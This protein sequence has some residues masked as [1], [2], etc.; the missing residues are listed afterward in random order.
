MSETQNRGVA[1]R[2]TGPLRVWWRLTTHGAAISLADQCVVSGLTFVVLM[3]MSAFA[4]LAQLGAFALAM[5]VVAMAIATQDALITRPYTVQIQ[6]CADRDTLRLR[7]SLMLAI[8]FSAAMFLLCACAGA[9]MVAV[10]YRAEGIIAFALAFALPGML[11]REFARRVSFAHDRGRDALMVDTPVAGAA[12]AGILLLGQ[13]GRLSAASALI[14][15]GIVNHAGALAWILSRGR[16]LASQ[17]APARTVAAES[18]I[19]GRWLFVCQMA[20]QAQGYA[21]HWLSMLFLGATA[22]GAYVACLSVVALANPVL[23]GLFNVMAPRSARMFRNAG[24]AG[25][26]RSAARDA[27][28]LVALMLGFCFFIAVFGGWLMARLYPSVGDAYHLLIVLSVSV[29]VGSAGVPASMALISA[30]RAK[31]LAMVVTATAL[32]TLAVVAVALPSWGLLGAAYG[33][34]LAEFVGSAGRWLALYHEAGGGLR[35]AALRPE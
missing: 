34:L 29:L 27:A 2:V 1:G 22:T 33:L 15:L 10:G 14:V 12:L 4:G 20:M 3:L 6:D 28:L 26:M 31:K 24:R 9:T 25:V 17:P 23:Y 5:S 18:W 21:T 16:L 32:F 13:T 8:A 11:L 30:N 19:M 7:A 35:T